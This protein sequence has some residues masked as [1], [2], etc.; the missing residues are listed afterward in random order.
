MHGSPD[1]R[2]LG[3]ADTARSASN[4]VTG[5]T[6]ASL[7]GQP[8]LRY[9]LMRPATAWWRL[10]RVGGKGTT[11][12]SSLGQVGGGLDGF[13]GLL[14]GAVGCRVVGKVGLCENA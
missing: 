9:S 4:G 8:A 3:E 1:A 2:S 7:G 11:A 10:I 13:D 5:A 12:G 6:W 14:K